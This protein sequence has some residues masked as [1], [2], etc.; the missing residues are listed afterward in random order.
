M[1]SLFFFTRAYC[2][3][4]CLRLSSSARR[5]IAGRRRGVG[6]GTRRRR[7]GA[8]AVVA[9]AGGENGGAAGR[10]SDGGDVAG[11]LDPLDGPGPAGPP[12]AWPLGRRYRDNRP[13]GRREP[14]P[15]V[16]NR[17]RPLRPRRPSSRCPSL[18]PGWPSWSC[19]GGSGTRSSPRHKGIVQKTQMLHSKV[20]FYI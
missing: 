14:E 20:L 11:P 1:S 7:W 17:R 4:C 13:P 12:L 5:R 8:P 15:A 19:S 10:G 3:H 2:F 16:A 6:G 18:F 9:S